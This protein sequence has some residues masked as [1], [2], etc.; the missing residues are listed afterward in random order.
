MREEGQRD[1]EIES[2]YLHL[3]LITVDCAREWRGHDTS[4]RDHHIYTF[5]AVA[6]GNGSCG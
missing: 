3:T 1:L 6:F 2:T 4:I 5:A